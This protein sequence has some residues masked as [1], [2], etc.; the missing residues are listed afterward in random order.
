MTEEEWQRAVP[1]DATGGR[2]GVVISIAIDKGYWLVF[3]YDDLRS[4]H[5][6]AP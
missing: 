6:A 2:L 1:V 4:N 5:T 3:D